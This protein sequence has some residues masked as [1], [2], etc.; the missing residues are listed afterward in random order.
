MAYKQ[1][2]ISVVRRSE[3]EVKGREGRE[4]GAV[5]EEMSRG[6]VA[7]VKAGPSEM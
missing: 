7:K 5:A 6:W 2:G 3:G 4:G 1:A